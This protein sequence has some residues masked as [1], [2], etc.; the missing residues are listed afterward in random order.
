M[1]RWGIVPWSAKSEDGFKKLSTILAKSDRLTES[2]MWREPFAN[3]RCLVPASGLDPKPGHAIAPTYQPEP[4]PI[5]AE[6][7]AGPGDLFGTPAPAR[8]GKKPKAIIAVAHSLLVIGYHLQAN[9]C[10]YQELGGNYFDRLHAEGLKRHLVKR[11]ESLG[12]TVT[13]QPRIA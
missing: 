13:L 11:L 4:E 1:M 8:P 12:L 7:S 6:A 5:A 9:C 2:N 10:A 3:R